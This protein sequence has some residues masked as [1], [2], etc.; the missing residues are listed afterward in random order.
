MRWPVFIF[1]AL[2]MLVLEK[3]LR[4]LLGIPGAFGVSPSFLLP[5]AVFVAL[6]TSRAA[7]MW[8]SLFLGL[9]VDLTTD[10]P[11]GSACLGYL[12]AVLVT[13]ELRGLVFRNSP[14]AIALMVFPAGIIA[15]LVIVALVTLRGAAWLPADAPVDWYASEQF[16]HR[17][18]IVLYS[19]VLA[20]PLGTVF[21]WLDPVW[22][23]GHHATGAHP[24]RERI[25]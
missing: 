25:T 2:T 13:F 9:L 16:V 6:S 12:A 10:M 3:G 23:F 19:A 20:L 21:V 5:L 24:Q 1:I 15:H 22:G 4:G 14:L 8:A 7:A 18:F 17:F 11:L